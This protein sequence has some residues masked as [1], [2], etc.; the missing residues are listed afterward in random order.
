LFFPFPV[1]FM[2]PKAT[3]EYITQI[4][5]WRTQREAELRSPDGWLSLCGLFVLTE[6][7]HT[8]GSGADCDIRLPASAP[9][10]LGLLEFHQGQASLVVTTAAPVLVDGAPMRQATLIDNSKRQ[11]PTLVTIG[12]ITLFIHK[13]GNSSAV[14]VRD[15][16]NPAI[17]AFQGCVWFPIQPDHRL[18]GQYVANAAPYDLPIQNTVQMATVY[19]SVGIVE[20]ELHGRL[21]RLAAA[22]ASSA[23]QRFI[24]LRDATAGKETYASARFLYVNVHADGSV[25]VD[26]NKAYHPPCAFT[27]YATCPLP[28]RENILSVPIAAGE[29]YRGTP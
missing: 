27:P 25:V 17:Q 3:T 29:R 9:D 13:V 21:L 5:R 22:E 11:K 7:R 2:E 28:P 15:S 19:R 14:R 23:D 4:E 8:I 20:F 18:I 16:L 26:F 1:S 6:G 10:Q 12:T 24:V